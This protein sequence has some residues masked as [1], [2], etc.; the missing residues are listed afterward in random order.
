MTMKMNKPANDWKPQVVSWNL[1]QGCNLRCP[2]CYLAAGESAPYELSTEEALKLID[3]LAEAGT[4]LLILTGGE[5]LL[6]RDLFELSA[7]AAER[8]LMVVLGT[9]GTL[10]DE[11]I[12]QRLKEC[13]V[14]G[15]GISLDSLDPQKHDAFRGL[16]G[17]WERAVRA[18]EICVAQGLEVAVQASVLPMN[19]A[20]ILEMI[21]FAYEKGAR[22]FNAYF[23]VC[24]GRGEKMTDITPQ[25]YE[26]LLHQL[27]EAQA[28]YLKLGLLIRAKCAPH[29][30]R[31]AYERLRE[32]AFGAGALAG[33][34][35]PAGTSY[36]RITPQGEVTPCPYLPFVVGN[37][38]HKPLSE[39]WQGS[40]IL[41]KLRSP[42]LGGRCGVCEFKEL[43]IGCRARA[44]AITGDLLGED[45]WCTYMPNGRDDACVAL[46]WTPEAEA[47]LRRIPP[48]IR[49]RVRQG[50]EAYAR[51]RG[52]EEITPQLLQEL[53]PA[54]RIT[55]QK[56]ESDVQTNTRGRG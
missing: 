13:G 5:P 11:R 50:A 12:A 55:N 38:R 1:T 21:E 56:E 33:S 16:P 7:H 42:E 24:T 14:R 10:I 2:H 53:R 45:P 20:E 44:F 3:Q 9:N 22:A 18:I 36:L 27:I 46:R 15:V 40:E 49:D 25:Q 34:G 6:R 17:A 41:Q 4:Q 30:K 19:C 54:F 48:F 47:R 8:G 37:I 29:V 43:C 52:I 39:I 26:A 28:R 31:L 32:G 51:A 23:L 35:C